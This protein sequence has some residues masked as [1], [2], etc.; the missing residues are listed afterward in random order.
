MLLIKYHPMKFRTPKTPG[1]CVCSQ[2]TWDDHLDL[3]EK[4]FSSGNNV[5]LSR[6]G[7][8]IE[9]GSYEEY[10]EFFRIKKI[11]ARSIEDLCRVYGYGVSTGVGDFQYASVKNIL[12]EETCEYFYH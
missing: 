3:C 10:L 4:V 5:V 2:R 7:D 11:D 6:N 12:K 1:F 9:V 8:F